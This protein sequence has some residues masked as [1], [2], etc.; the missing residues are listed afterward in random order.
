MLLSSHSFSLPF[1]P[2]HSLQSQ[3]A[4]E[5]EEVGGVEGG[6][7]EGGVL[8]FHFAEGHV[9]HEG[10]G[11]AVEVGEGFVHEEELEGLAEGAHGGDTLALS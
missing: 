9:G 11:V 4:V 7:E 1:T 6:E 2:F 5:G 3:S 10:R 8:G